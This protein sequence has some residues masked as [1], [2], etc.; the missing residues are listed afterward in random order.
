MHTKSTKFNRL[1][2]VAPRNKELQRP[3]SIKTAP[4]S[5]TQQ[6]I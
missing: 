2:K 1:Q 3:Q 5:H 6:A 4:K